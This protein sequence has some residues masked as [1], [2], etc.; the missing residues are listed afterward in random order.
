MSRADLDPTMRGQYAQWLHRDY[1]CPACGEDRALFLGHDRRIRCVC[2]RQ[3]VST[4]PELVARAA[5]DAELERWRAVVDRKDAELAHIYGR[6]AELD[7][8]YAATQAAAERTLA[9]PQR[10]AWLRDRAA[11]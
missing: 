10:V 11:S 3:H 9:D 2:C 5:V 6:L 7:A 8:D 4:L 1:R